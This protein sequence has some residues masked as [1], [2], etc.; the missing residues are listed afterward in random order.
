MSG[1]DMC[2]FTQ[3]NI[4]ILRI[5]TRTIRRIQMAAVTAL[6]MRLWPPYSQ[7]PT[8][9]FFSTNFAFDFSIVSTKQ[10]NFRDNRLCFSSLYIY[11][12]RTRKVYTPTKQRTEDDCVC[13]FLLFFRYLTDRTLTIYTKCS[14]RTLL[15]LQL[16]NTRVDGERGDSAPQLRSIYLFKLQRLT[17]MI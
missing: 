14:Q 1:L 13:V 12:L 5:Q 7:P 9:A 15:R 3:S 8:S 11:I 4:E 2:F 17:G 16:L 10:S 6:R